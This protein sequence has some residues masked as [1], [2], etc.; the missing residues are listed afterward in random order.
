MS[1]W[2]SIAGLF[3][4]GG[5]DTAAASAPLP[6]FSGDQA[7]SWSIGLPPGGSVETQPGGVPPGSV[8]GI[9]AAG[10]GGGGGGGGFLSMI[11]A[12]GGLAMGLKNMFTT[13]PTEAAL[14]KGQKLQMK[15]AAAAGKAGRQQLSQ[16]E[17]GMLSPAQQASVDKFRQ[18]Q[19]AKW[20]QYL[21]SAGIPE[22]S[23]MVDIENKV[24][25]DVDAYKN[26]LLQQNFQNS[27]SA[28]GLS[29]NTLAQAAQ[30]N[31]L[32]E[33]EIAASQAAAMK[34]IGEIFGAL[35]A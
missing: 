22:S 19:L 33:R 21:A 3:G 18:E 24:N 12:I 31:I 14:E 6:D 8:F 11:P 5:A 7:G 30:A 34:A 16:Y 13:S 9:P 4:G 32:Q 10:G 29:G 25:Q 17:Q 23:A 15:G 35:G 1:L 26:Q 2:D 28:L 27:M 20:R